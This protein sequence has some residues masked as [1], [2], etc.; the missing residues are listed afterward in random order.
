MFEVTLI[1][2][3]D[4]ALGA[5]GGQLSLIERHGQAL[6]LALGQG[7]GFLGILKQ[8]CQLAVFPRGLQRYHSAHQLVN[9]PLA[10]LFT[11]G[12]GSGNLCQQGFAL[13]PQGQNLAI[14]RHQLGV[15]ALEQGHVFI[16][17]AGTGSGGGGR[18]NV[19]SGL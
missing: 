10:Q 7:G 13:L 17:A 1:A 2:S 8:L 14:Q 18:D 12:F 3:G 15:F 5:V 19:Q 6:F 16:Q 11:A 9:P 4:H